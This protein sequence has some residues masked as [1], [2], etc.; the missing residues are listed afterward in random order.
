MKIRDRIIDGI[1]LGNVPE[2]PFDEI[3]TV[4][5]AANAEGSVLLKNDGTL[6]LKKGDKIAVFGRVQ[7]EYYKSGTG[8]GGKVNTKYV[9]NIFDSLKQS[10]DVVINEEVSET[11]AKWCEKNPFDIGDG[12]NQPWSQTE[13]PLTEELCKN[14][15]AVS[16]KAIVIIGRTAGESKDNSADKGSYNLSD[17]EYDMLKKVSDAFDKVCVVLNVG[18]IIDMK[19]A[20]E[21]DISAVLY[22]WHGG[23]EGGAAT[24][25]LLLGKA[26][27]SGKLSDTI[28][29]NIEDYPSFEGFSNDDENVYIEDIFVGYRYFET[30]AKDKVMYPFGFGMGY[31]EFEVKTLSAEWKNNT[32][33]VKAEVKNTGKF[34]GKETVQIYCGGEGEKLCR[35]SREL[36]ALRK[37]AN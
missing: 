23:Q 25:D 12:W 19:W 11:Y 8:S 20:E 21:L 5:R 30:F 16:D 35:P 14:A 33:F 1:C 15:A 22:V 34:A 24:A 31:T 29:Y 4:S 36:K 18:N 6:P 27:P 13:M 9:T 10:S 32:V 26:F 7:R 17:G 37:R 28:V 2:G 3:N